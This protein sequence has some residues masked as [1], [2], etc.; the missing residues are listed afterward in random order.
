LENNCYIQL[1]RLAVE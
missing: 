1:Q